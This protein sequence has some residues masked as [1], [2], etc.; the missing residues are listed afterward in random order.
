MSDTEN[1]KNYVY[2]WE[3]FSFSQLRES[4]VGRKGLSLFRLKDMDVPVPSFF[5]VGSDVFKETVMQSLDRDGTKL[6][7]K[8]RNPE[9]EEILSSILKT[10]FT[11]EIR[12][13]I[14][15]AYTRISGFTDAWVSVRSS[16]VFT[17]RQDVSF[18]GIFSTELNVRGYNELEDSIKKVFS[19]MFSDDVVAYAARMN[20]DLA[21]VKIAVVVQKMVQA[22]VSGVAFTIDPITQDETKLSIEAV[23]GLGEV[24]ASGEITPD[25]YLLKKK[26][27]TLIEKHISPQEWMMVRTVARGQR[28]TNFEKVKISA[29]WSHRQ[30]IEDRHLQEISKIALIV[31]SK[32]RNAQNIEWV[33]AG[34]KIWLLQSKT[35]Y[36]ESTKQSINIGGMERRTLGEVVGAMIQKYRG[37][38]D[39]QEKAVNEAQRIVNRNKSQN[40]DMLV[41]VA[42]N[43]PSE[44]GTLIST[45]KSKDDYLT[46]G[47][48]ASF[49][50]VTGKVVIIDEKD[51]NKKVDRNT[52]LVIKKYASEMESFILSAGGIVLETGGLT[53]DI[54][55]MCREANIP[56]I[57]GTQEISTFLKNGDIVRIDGKSGNIYKEN[58]PAIMQRLKQASEYVHPVVDSYVK[59]ELASSPPE[60]KGIDSEMKRIKEEEESNDVEIPHDFTLPPSATKVFIEGFEDSEKIVE[61]VGNSHG[62]V[63][64]DLDKI[65]LEDGRHLLAYVEDKKFVDFSNKLSEKISEYAR[66]A[67]GNEVVL[68]IGSSRVEKF[69]ELVKGK[70]FE[71]K[72]LDDKAFG[73]NHYLSNPELLSRVLR[74]VKKIRNVY[75]KRNI[76]IGFHAPMNSSNVKEF[77]K[78]LSSLGLKRGTSFNVYAVL[79][80]PTEI[81]LADEIVKAGVDGL[82]LNMPRIVRQMQG[83]DIESSRAKYDLGVNSVLRVVDN[84][85]EIVRSSGKRVTV[86]T[87]SNKDLVKHCVNAGVY[88]VTVKPKDISE[89]RKV[90]SQEESK[91]ILGK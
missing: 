33:F 17:E 90:V 3:D 80:N 19:S 1:T 81:I 23:Y 48:G 71:N 29:A 83:F 22:E 40:T 38:I 86:V 77:K 59:E 5:V 70:N 88:G 72:D 64:V 34:G 6:L 12:D 53:S 26:D 62:I 21:D 61:Y 84:I 85:L 75:K 58:D 14:L 20:I 44:K 43:I 7:G 67:E 66:I 76:S 2:F 11:A 25:T 28:K 74:I 30:K 54:S 32:A 41:E 78:T 18:S 51:F 45:N 68:T 89:Y 4:T 49:G 69:R 27:L 46:T 56:A 47:I 36:E 55:I 87:E 52:I 10:E 8:N 60:Y 16:V 57:V 13:Q 37:Q 9:E 91:L 35:L 42:R 24:I 65:L 73:L 63:F 79:D 82:I 15:S 31:E 50:T 39:I